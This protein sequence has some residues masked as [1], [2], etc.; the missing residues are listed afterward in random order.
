MDRG[1]SPVRMTMDL[2]ATDGKALCLRSRFMLGQCAQSKC[3]AGLGPFVEHLADP[4]ER[5]EE[6]KRVNIACK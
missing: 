4:K 1:Q 3:S 6:T 2:R 5:K